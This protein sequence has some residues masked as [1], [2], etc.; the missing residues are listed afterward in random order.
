MK[1]TDWYERSPARA[2][3][4]GVLRHELVLRV[5]RHEFVLRVLHHEL[6]LLVLRRRPAVEKFVLIASC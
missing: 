5:L 3:R 2:L 6:V 1:T 4:L